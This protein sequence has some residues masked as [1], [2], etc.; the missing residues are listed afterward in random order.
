MRHTD[1]I[2]AGASEP[3]KIPF[4]FLTPTSVKLVWASILLRWLPLHQTGLRLAEICRSW[5]AKGHAAAQPISRENKLKIKPAGAKPNQLFHLNHQ[6]SLCPLNNPVSSPTQFKSKGNYI[7]RQMRRQSGFDFH[8]VSIALAVLT[9]QGPSGCKLGLNYLNG[10][11]NTNINRERAI[12]WKSW[13]KSSADSPS[14]RSKPEEHRRNHYLLESVSVIEFFWAWTG[15]RGQSRATHR[16]FQ[17]GKPT[18]LTL[19]HTESLLH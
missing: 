9:L 16:F 5:W 8:S 19:S 17:T 10:I 12:P 6:I 1:D 14:P 4:L 7:T 3:Y 15:V 11:W 18:G 2:G 13:P